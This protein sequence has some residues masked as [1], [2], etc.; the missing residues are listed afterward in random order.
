M[1]RILVCVTG[2]VL[3]A[4][5]GTSTAA[6]R[7]ET[8]DRAANPLETVVITATRGPREL[9][10]VAG[11]V[12]VKTAGQVERELARDIKDLVRYEPGISVSNSAGRFGLGG[13]NVRGIDANRVLIEID[14]VPVPDSFS[15]GSFASAGRDFVDLEILKGVEILRGAASSLYGSDAIGGVVAFVT[16]DPVDL[17]PSGAESRHA[18]GRAAWFGGDDSYAATATGAWGG[19]ALSAMLVYSRREGHELDNQGS[20]AALDS[21]RTRPDPQDYE[22]DTVLGKL[23]WDIADGQRLRLTLED[24]RDSSFTDAISGR[25]T[26]LLGPATVQTLDLTGDDSKARR[27][28]ALDHEFSFSGGVAEEGRWQ[29]Y[30]QDSETLQRTEEL[31]LSSG[32]GPPSESLRNRRARFNQEVAGGELTLRKSFATA[33]TAHT[34][35]YGIELLRT[36]SEQFRDGSQTDLATGEVTNVVQPDTFPVRDFPLTETIEAALFAQDEIELGQGRWTVVPGV[37]ADYYDLNPDADA[38]YLEDNPL[39]P[40]EGMDHTSLSPKLGVVRRIG[41]ALSAYAQYAQGF[42]APPYG[43]VNVG[44]TNLAFGYTAIPN[45]DLEPET[46]YGFEIGLRGG[47]GGSHFSVAAFHNDYDDLIESLVATGVDPD[48]GLLVFQ[49]QNIAKARIYGAE[50]RGGLDL[51]SFSDGLAGWQLRSSV[52]WAHGDDRTSNE[53]LNSVDPLK[54]VLGIA[55]SG[56]NDRWG[57]ELILTMVDRKDRI[58]ES[59]GLQFSAPRHEVLDLLGHV[60]LG[61]KVSLRAGITNLTDEKYWEWADVRGRPAGDPVIDRYSRPGRAASASINIRF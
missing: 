10:D 18:G 14:G 2:A 4:A 59:F 39:S 23:V 40:A 15:I 5:L 22:S 8:G 51:G 60:N 38:I 26:Q 42:R 56:A 50:F 49:S 24:G 21:T 31:R 1:N 27:R 52:A 61:P 45:P 43:D 7:Q 25:R 41:D 3:A 20:V 12:T 13:F 17:L 57:T 33:A 9:Q 11:T 37:R 29:L 30:W 54:G 44:F 32:F 58:D 47:E 55:Y 16:K 36:D 6:E 34:L 53:P 35:T 28:I 19:E 46:S 48:S